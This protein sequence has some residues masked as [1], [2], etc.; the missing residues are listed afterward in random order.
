MPVRANLLVGPHPARQSGESASFGFRAGTVKEVRITRGQALFLEGDAAEHFFDI[1]RGTLRCCRLIEDGRRQIHRFAKTGDMLGIGCERLYDYSAEAI[2]DV[3][4]RRYP[5]A[6]LDQAMMTYETLRRRVLHALRAELAATRAH[7]MLLGRLSAAEKLSSFLLGM[8]GDYSGPE[9]RIDLP[10]TRGDIADYLGLTIE[11]VS[12]KLSDL[13]G[14]GVIRLETP[15][16]VQLI[17]LHRIEAN[18]EAA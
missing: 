2:T 11:T 3:T 18:A 14:L 12:R 8:A 16:R 4:A 5:L 15:N 6:D 17:G 1:T 13:N 10:M 9:T 7:M